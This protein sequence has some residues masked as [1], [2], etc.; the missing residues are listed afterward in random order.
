M[1]LIAKLLLSLL[2]AIAIVAIT[3]YALRDTPISFDISAVVVYYLMVALVMFL[4][5][6]LIAKFKKN[7]MDI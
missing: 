5:I 6:S 2:I 1:N 3:L 4:V 7:R